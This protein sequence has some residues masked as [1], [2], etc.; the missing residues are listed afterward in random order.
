MWSLQC[1]LALL[2]YN[3]VVTIA[4]NHNGKTNLLAKLRIL[5]DQDT[6][7]EGLDNLAKVILH[8]ER[9]LVQRWT[10]CTQTWALP[11]LILII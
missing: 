2:F 11:I 8:D 7:F 4:Q 9:D 5:Q 10:K 1:L 6:V 3:V